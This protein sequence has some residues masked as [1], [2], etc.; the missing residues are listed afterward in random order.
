M[1]SGE[2][3][4]RLWAAA[5]RGEVSND[6]FAAVRRGIETSFAP[7]E[8][9]AVAAPPPAGRGRRL[10]FGRWQASRPFAGNWFRLV[11]AEAPLDALDADELDRDRARAVLERYGVVFRELLERELPALGW[12]RLF[13]AL[14]LMELSGEVVA[15]QFFLGLGG[16][17]FALPSALRRLQDGGGDEGVA[18]MN[19]ADPASPC[20]LSLE[21]GLPLPR[22]VTTSHL[23]LH[24]GRVVAV[25]ERRGKALVLAIGPE[26][27]RLPDVLAFLKVMLTRPVR[28]LRAVRVETING[29]PAAT[30]PYREALASLFH[31]TRDGGTLRLGRRY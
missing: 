30:S 2:L 21:L 18:W 11:P 12:G 9:E 7:A 22:R 4:R 6:G 23:V 26:H 3:A 5:W 10:R 14:R 27:P 15:G 13:R 1:P 25:S 20:G 28:P 19:A 8:T 31:I 16:L 17:Q 24:G 29:E